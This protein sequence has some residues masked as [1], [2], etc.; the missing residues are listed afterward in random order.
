M[1]GWVQGFIFGS[2]ATNVLGIGHKVVPA[3]K[4]PTSLVLYIDPGLCLNLTD[5]GI[6]EE[7]RTAYQL[8][9][10]TFAGLDQPLPKNT[11]NHQGTLMLRRLDCAVIN[12][13]H[14]LRAEQGQ[15]A[16]D[17]VYGVFEEGESLFPGSALKEKTHV[18]LAVRNPQTLLGYFRPHQLADFIN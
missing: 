11:L 5:F 13:L 6:N 10:Q 8:L 1:T 3:F 16:F 17:T 18:Q 12:F 2:T 14:Q 9:E 15:P 4:T 7:L